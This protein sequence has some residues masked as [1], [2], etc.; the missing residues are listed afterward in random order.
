MFPLSHHQS[1]TLYFHHWNPNLRWWSV[2]RYSNHLC[3]S[4]CVQK[5]LHCY[6][7]HL[8]NRCQCTVHVVEIFHYHSPKHQCLSTL[9][10]ELFG[11]LQCTRRPAGAQ[12]RCSYFLSTVSSP[13]EG[14]CCLLVYILNIAIANLLIF[15]YWFNSPSTS[16][17]N[18][19]RNSS[20][21][22]GAG[23]MIHSKSIVASA[24]YI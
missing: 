11:Q 22:V 4:W 24:L 8:H 10:T 3:Y 21:V 16:G 2:E 19:W 13:Q 14:C 12:G 17:C 6:R 1:N 9:C 23:P 15:K 5:Q 7:C 20:D 18:N